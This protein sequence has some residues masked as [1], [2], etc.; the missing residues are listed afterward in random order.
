MKRAPTPFSG[1]RIRKRSDKREGTY[2]HQ[3]KGRLQ[4]NS[5]G[6]GKKANGANQN[7]ANV[8]G[9]LVSQSRAYPQK[10]KKWN[11]KKRPELRYQY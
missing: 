9:G 10:R 8:R 2:A 7:V 5:K 6:K 4:K 3:Q 1:H 11:Y